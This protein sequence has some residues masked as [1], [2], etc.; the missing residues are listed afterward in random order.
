MR[1]EREAGLGHAGLGLHCGRGGQ[2]L[3][4]FVFFGHAARH[5]AS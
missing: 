1:P 2:S 3:R 4:V 5:V